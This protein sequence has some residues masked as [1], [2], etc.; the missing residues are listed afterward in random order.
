MQSVFLRS[1]E[2]S[3]SVEYIF[4]AFACISAIFHNNHFSLLTGTACFDRFDGGIR[5]GGIRLKF[6]FCSLSLTGENQKQ[7]SNVNP[8]H[9][10]TSSFPNN[11]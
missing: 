8:S 7:Y 11:L 2:A 3:A 10:K 1:A 4:L 6:S 5:R 9:G